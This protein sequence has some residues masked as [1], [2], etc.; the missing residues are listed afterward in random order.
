MA[1]KLA[2]DYW[3]RIKGEWVGGVGGVVF[4]SNTKPFKDIRSDVEGEVESEG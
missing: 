1:I 2:K 3:G 4:L